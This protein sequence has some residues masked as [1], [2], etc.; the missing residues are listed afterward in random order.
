MSAVN[1]RQFSQIFGNNHHRHHQS[2]YRTSS[3][4]NG[5]INRHLDGTSSAPLPTATTTTN[6]IYRSQTQSSGRP[7][8]QFKLNSLTDTIV[9]GFLFQH[10]E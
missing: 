3:N 7:M 1:P 5:T 10:L 4:D 8:T 6:F 9:R 2:I